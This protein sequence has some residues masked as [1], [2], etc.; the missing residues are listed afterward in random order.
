MLSTKKTIK[1]NLLVN[2]EET[3]PGS[4]TLLTLILTKAGLLRFMPQSYATTSRMQFEES[5][6]SNGRVLARLPAESTVNG[7]I[8][9]SPPIQK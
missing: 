3:Q 8:G 4:Q 2:E 6:A 5:L 9:L 7:E 1:N